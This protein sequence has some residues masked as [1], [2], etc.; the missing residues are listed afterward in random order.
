MRI[1]KRKP[2]VAALLSLV[3]PG[4]GQVYNGELLKGTVLFFSCLF[5]LPLMILL[6]LQHRFNGLLVIGVVLMACVILTCGEA[7]YTATRKKEMMLKPYNRW[8]YYLLIGV[9]VVACN[10]ASSNIYSVKTWGLKSYKMTSESM[11]PTLMNGDR[12]IV[13]LKYYWDKRPQKGDI[14]VFQYP[15][16]PSV[17]FV[18]RIVATENDVVESKNEI[19]YINGVAMNEPYIQHV[20][21]RSRLSENFEPLTVPKGCVFVLGDNRDRSM[22]SRYFGNITD[23]QIRGKALYVYWSK[24]RNRIGQEIK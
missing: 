15:K 18:K 4:L 5:T 13:D 16:D 20:S 7:F 21:N 2:I 23:T 8:Y 22:D 6:R 9:L 24:Q 1:K 19:I 3:I 17:D 10:I 12:I 14:I 11:L